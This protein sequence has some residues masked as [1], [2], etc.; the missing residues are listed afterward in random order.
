M[1]HHPYGLEPVFFCP[2]LILCSVQDNGV[3]RGAQRRESLIFCLCMF[4]VSLIVLECS[5]ACPDLQ[6]LCK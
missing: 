5:S 1:L 6:L 3:L 2:L 4:E